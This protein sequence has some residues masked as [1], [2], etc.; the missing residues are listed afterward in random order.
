MRLFFSR[1]FVACAAVA[2]FA[3]AAQAATTP[4]PSLPP[5]MTPAVYKMVMTPGQPHPPGLPAGVVP[6]AGCIP[7]MGFH[8][9]APGKLPFGPI[10]GWYDGKPIFTE[11]M[12]AKTSF[13]N[14]MSW[15]E[16]LQPLPG[17]TIDHVDFWY[18]AHGHPG[19]TVP[20][21][22]IHAWYVKHDVHMYYCGNTSGKK[23][24][25]L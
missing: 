11:I 25:W 1:A 12:V 20:H 7:T 8:Y 16:Q 17:Y 21:Y 5:G 23:P 19:Y 2:L 24:I 4:P 10:Y 15:N 13:E 22:D 6:V 9:A 3:S 18:E 14:G